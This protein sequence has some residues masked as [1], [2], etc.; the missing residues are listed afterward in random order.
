[1]R[2]LELSPLLIPLGAFDALTGP[3]HSQA[4]MNLLLLYD[5]D[6]SC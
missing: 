3:Y 6:F 2:V 1:M 4:K 5:G